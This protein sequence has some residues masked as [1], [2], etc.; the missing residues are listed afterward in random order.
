MMNKMV[1]LAAGLTLTL[2]GPVIAADQGSSTINPGV[3]A[4]RSKYPANQ[5]RAAERVGNPNAKDS[6]SV[7]PSDNRAKS[8]AAQDRS[9]ERIGSASDDSASMAR[10]DKMQGAA[11]D[12]CL[13]Q[14]REAAARKAPG[15]TGGTRST[16]G[17]GAGSSR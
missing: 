10:C 2:A 16:T 12:R 4:D 17:T 8:P 14:A 7:M 1:W 3:G 6:V 11:R 13:D 15:A 5:D 9:G